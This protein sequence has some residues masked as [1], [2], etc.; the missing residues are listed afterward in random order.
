L[1]PL[2]AGGRKASGELAVQGPAVD[3][4]D[5]RLHQLDLIA[6]ALDAQLDVRAAASGR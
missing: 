5:A 2:L 1:F 6:A 3:A 4:E